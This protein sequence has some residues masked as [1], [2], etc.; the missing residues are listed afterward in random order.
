MIAD[1]AFTALDVMRENMIFYH[2]KAGELMAAILAL[3]TLTHDEVTDAQMHA[4]K[5]MAGLLRMRE[6]A[7]QCAR[8]LAPYVHSKADARRPEK[9]APGAPR[10]T[11]IP[12]PKAVIEAYE[13]AAAGL[14]PEPRRKL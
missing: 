4:L 12:T 7:Q 6:L 5:D 9:G 8:D 11:H 10:I 13:R 14:P 1:P 2:R 3:P